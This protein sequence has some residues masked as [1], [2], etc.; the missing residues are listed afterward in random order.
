M[1]FRKRTVLLVGFW[2]ILAGIAGLL[3]ILTQEEWLSKQLKD[4]AQRQ[5]YP[6]SSLRIDGISLNGIELSDLH[7]GEGEAAL[8]IPRATIGFH[9]F[10]STKRIQEISLHDIVIPVSVAEGAIYIEAI[11]TNYKGPANAAPAAELPDSM[12]LRAADIQQLPFDVLRIENAELRF[13]GDVQGK[14]PFNAR[15]DVYPKPEIRLDIKRPLISY[16]Q[17][18]NVELA[19]AYLR[20]KWADDQ[21]WEGEVSLMGVSGSAPDLPELAGVNVNLMSRFTWSEETFSGEATVE[22][23]GKQYSL[24]ASYQADPVTQHAI[25]NLTLPPTSLGKEGVHILS[26]APELNEQVESVSGTLGFDIQ[27]NLSKKAVQGNGALILND[28][29]ITT[30]GIPI[31]GITDTITFAQLVPP[32][33]KNRQQLKPFTVNTEP[34]VTVSSVIYSMDWPVLTVHD[35]SAQLMEGEISVKDIHYDISSQNPSVNTT[36]RLSH[37]PLQ[38]LMESFS[39]AKVEA[40]GTVGGNIPITYKKGRLAINDATLQAEETGTINMAPLLKQQQGQVAEVLSSFED[41]NYDVLNISIDASE[42]GK[43]KATLYLEGKNP[44][45]FDGRPIHLTVNL[46]GDLIE[47]MKGALNIYS[48]PEKIQERITQQ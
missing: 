21:E 44:E 3:F 35:L 20:M 36:I 41:F 2:L 18:T 40:T 13:R 46:S 31:R 5:G 30:Q 42:S 37:F 32:R 43:Q 45:A 29:D 39:D 17:T 4:Y 9:S 10:F 11:A 1:A 25:V 26:Y 23:K 33:T 15:L 27:M 19:M 7:I 34:P 16:M 6:V 47:T 22:P 28:I 38:P 14:I 24:K 12:F 48:L 8:E